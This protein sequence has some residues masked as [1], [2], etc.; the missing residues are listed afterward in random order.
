MYPHCLRLKLK[1]KNIDCEHAQD[2]L[3]WRAASQVNTYLRMVNGRVGSKQDSNN[4]HARLLDLIS[5][6][7]HVKTLEQADT[8][9]N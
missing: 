9:I 8:L 5:T 4:S 6:I 3:F 2:Q 7:Q 1:E